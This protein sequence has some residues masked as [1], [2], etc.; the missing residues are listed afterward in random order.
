MRIMA[1]VGT[2]ALQ[3]LGNTGYFVPCLHSVGERAP[4]RGGSVKAQL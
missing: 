4:R 2:G 1:R 3:V